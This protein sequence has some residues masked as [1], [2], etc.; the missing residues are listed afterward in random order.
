VSCTAAGSCIAVGEDDSSTH[1]IAATEANNAWAAAGEISGL[2]S[3]ASG[4]SLSG[5][6]CQ[7]GG[8]CTAVG[9]AAISGSNQPMAMNVAAG[10]FGQGTTV[11]VPSGGTS[12][13]LNSVACTSPGNC[14]AVGQYVDGSGQTE[15]M[16][17]SETAGSWGQA[18]EIALPAGAAAAQ[19]ATL[20]SIACPGTGSCKAVGS[21]DNSSGQQTAMLVLQSGATWGQAIQFSLPTGATASQFDSISCTNSSNCTTTG[22]VV[23]GTTA[24]LSAT[25]TAGTWSVASAL[26]VPSGAGSSG[27]LSAISLAVGCVGASHCDAAGTYPVAAG[28]GAMTLDSHPSLA[29]TSTTLPAG[30]VGK[31]YSAQ[32]GSSG[33]TGGNVWTF[34]GGSLPAGLIF[35]ATGKITGTPTTD[36]TTTFSVAVHDNASPPDQAAGTVSI[37]IGP[38]TKPPK[39]TTGKSGSSSGKGGKKKSKKTKGA[40]V[41][42]IKVLH[43]SWVHFT[44]KCQRQRRCDGRVAVVVIEHFRA[45]KLIAVNATT[46][47]ARGTRTKTVWLGSVRYALRDG[48]K[49]TKTI[50]MNRTGTRLLKAYHHLKAGVALRPAS[51][52]RANIVHTV[53][54]HELKA[55]KHK[56]HAGKHDGKHDGHHKK[57]KHKGT[58]S[59]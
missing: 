7:A 26:P 47:R 42:G 2:P 17:A 27:S 6:S 44:V 12:G 34:T 13:T 49:L 3:G 52:K 10:V 35:S 29:V 4:G 40:K 45:K 51:F 39:T 37:R 30:A 48:K 36:Q 21:Y 57:D 15:A 31:A 58:H 9:T 20:S 22:S 25:D 5:I 38:A 56:K 55:K 53:K 46:H 18:T 33:G 50:H 16:A 41:G 32:I 14:A 43:G 28:V 54:L 24:P 8:N 1:P 19:G 23:A 11:A 59:A